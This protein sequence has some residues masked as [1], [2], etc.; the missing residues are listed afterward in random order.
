MSHNAYS[1]SDHGW[2]ARAGDAHHARRAVCAALRTGFAIGAL[3]GALEVTWT[4]LLPLIRREFHIGFC[5]TIADFAAFILAATT[6]DGLLGAGLS[7]GLLGIRCC[8]RSTK[9]RPAKDLDRIGPPRMVLLGA[10]GIYLFHGWT[11]QLLLAAGRQQSAAQ[12]MWWFLGMLAA[13]AL[14]MCIGIRLER[15]SRRGRRRAPA[16]AWSVAV[17]TAILASIAI[18]AHCHRVPAAR[19]CTS[20]PQ[21]AGGPNVILITI[22]T[23]RADHAGCY[24]H[25]WIQTPTLDALARDGLV[26]EAAISQAPSTTPSHCSLMTS[27]YPF[28]HE[29]EN[30]RPM[31]PDL[32][33]L[34]EALSSL[35]YETAAFVS[36]TTT[37][38]VN[39]GL[40]KGFERYV[41]SLVPWSEFFGRDELQHLIFFY[42][43]N[44]VQSTQIPG[45]VVTARAS[46]WLSRRAAGPFFVWLHYFDP[47]EP[48][49]APRP[50]SGMYADKIADGLPMPVERARYAEDVTYADDC[51]GN[52]IETLKRA[53]IYDDALIIVTS[54]H[55][56]A[57]GEPH[58]RIVEVGHG[59][60]L[61]DVTQRVPLIIKLPGA[62]RAS[63]RIERQVELVDLAP[64]ILE[65]VGAPI[66]PGFCGQS[67]AGLLA[68][69]FPPY[70]RQY[71][72]A[73]NTLYINE[74]AAENG[75]LYLRQYAAR[76]A[77]WKCIVRPRLS[78]F[79][80][81]DLCVDPGERADV[82]EIHP[83]VFDLMHSQLAPFINSAGADPS[84]PR[85]GLSP[86]LIQELQALGYLGD[87]A[88]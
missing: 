42:L 37:R 23:L 16:T 75:R 56:E 88:D 15:A 58:G 45:E 67:L 82:S 65:Y 5:S 54:D 13:A 3:A 63:T 43:A 11:T 14:M 44:I 38:S 53:G 84:D 48:Y 1:A 41:D 76:T 46:R 25:P 36:A 52:W 17:A 6:I 69:R 20:I 19:A 35:G 28:E 55:G 68:D 86:A 59:H 72:Y 2:P 29:G 51:L 79:E 12:R 30:G 22:D 85:R 7:L 80:L 77:Y 78:E 26:F 60:Y 61:S 21:S 70:T 87:P 10:M 83:S 73:F 18:F 81:Y 39:T 4:V 62:E 64:T 57:F 33:T 50:F 24:G 74:P 31:K 71:A 66:P 34:A 49:G 8:L 32:V 27:V 9:T 40:H 47:H